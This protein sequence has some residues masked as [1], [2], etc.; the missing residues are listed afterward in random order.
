MQQVITYQTPEGLAVVYPTGEIPL[1]EVIAREVPEGVSHAVINSEE[2]PDRY[3]REAWEYHG[4]T[5]AKVNIEKAKEVQRNVWRRMR[6]KKFAVLDLEVM[7]AVERGDA[8]RRNALA[9]KKQA[10]RDV[11]EHPL[12]DN[13]EEIKNTIPDILT[14]N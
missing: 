4:P 12:P 8:K 6:E 1:E 11:T 9:D 7:K 5:G 13:P 3:F 2:L 10:L 14:E